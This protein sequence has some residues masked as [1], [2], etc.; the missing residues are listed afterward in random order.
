M[1]RLIFTLLVSVAGFVATVAFANPDARSDETSLD[2]Q[3]QD[4][5]SPV[6]IASAKPDARRIGPV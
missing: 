3:S 4:Q 2:R 1:K 5:D 6:V